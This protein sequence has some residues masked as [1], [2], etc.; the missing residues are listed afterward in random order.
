[1]S[2]H[3]SS[4]TK[5]F[6]YYR[7]P[8]LY[9]SRA[10]R[11]HGSSGLRTYAFLGELSDCLE[12]HD[13]VYLIRPRLMLEQHLNGALFYPSPPVNVPLKVHLAEPALRE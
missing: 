3:P 11:E 10:Q 9:I 8:V 2:Y 13:V 5:H 6:E 4:L 7:A 1:M 12:L